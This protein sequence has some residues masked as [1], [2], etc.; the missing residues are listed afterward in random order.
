MVVCWPPLLSLL[1]YQR[2]SQL[3]SHVGNAQQRECEGDT[4]YPERSRK[5]YRVISNP[6]LLL[7]SLR[8]KWRL[9]V[10]FQR[11]QWQMQMASQINVTKTRVAK[12]G[13]DPGHAK[14][15]G[16]YFCSGTQDG[17]LPVVLNTRNARGGRVEV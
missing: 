8:S 4:M 6:R 13:G 11:G 5:A 9:K 16:A 14:K 12:F 17:V 1:L 10:V 7:R 15:K 3:A 2:P